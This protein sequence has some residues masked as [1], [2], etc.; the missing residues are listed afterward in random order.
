MGVK[1]T[2]PFAD[3]VRAEKFVKGR[4]GRVVDLVEMPDEYIFG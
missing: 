4:D 1:G 3:K 2:F